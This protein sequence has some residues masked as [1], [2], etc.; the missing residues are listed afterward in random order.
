MAIGNGQGPLHL[1]VPDHAPKGN[2]FSQLKSGMPQG[3]P[4]LGE[5][6][7]FTTPSSLGLIPSDS[8]GPKNLLEASLPAQSQPPKIRK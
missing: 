3:D 1:T 4:T 8:T 7:A 6:W 5:N 2:S